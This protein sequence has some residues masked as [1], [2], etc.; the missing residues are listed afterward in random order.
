MNSVKELVSYG[1]DEKTANN[2]ISIFQSKVG[3]ING[4]Y[5]IVDIT[6]RPGT[7]IRTVT[8]KCTKCG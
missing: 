1:I 5:K 7:R 6:F 2:M 8:L 4:D 3:T